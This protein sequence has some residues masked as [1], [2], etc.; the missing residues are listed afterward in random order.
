MV[1]VVAVET[2][3]STTVAMNNVA[4]VCCALWYFLLGNYAL[5]QINC[6]IMNII[7]KFHIHYDPQY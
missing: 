5:H 7:I 4:Q 3:T 6:M 1:G 2:A